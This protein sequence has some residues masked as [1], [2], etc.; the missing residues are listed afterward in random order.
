MKEQEKNLVF[1]SFAEKA[2]KQI[3]EKRKLLIKK[4]YVE[5]ADVEL[6]L[7]GMSRQEISDSYDFSENQIEND[8]YLL[9]CACPEL[10]EAA[11]M[12]IEEGSLKQHYKITE[13]FSMAD[14]KELLRTVLEL[15]G[16]YQK[17]SVK[18]LDEVEEIKNS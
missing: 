3:E 12:M 8:N 2:K 15:S 14:Q 6:T 16:I 1:I 7:R 18:P 9:Y 10:Q 11:K 5:D 17:S 4:V 13:M